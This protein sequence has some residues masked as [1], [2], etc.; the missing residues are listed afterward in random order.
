MIPMAPPMDFWGERPLDS[1]AIEVFPGNRKEPFT[2]Y[3]DDGL[4]EAYRRGAAATTEF[5]QSLD[6][7][8]LTL[9]VA[10]RKGRYAGM[11]ARRHYAFE[12]H[13]PKPAAVRVNGKPTNDWHYDEEAGLLA[14]APLPA[15]TRRPLEIQAR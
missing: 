6:G 12:I 4:T 1:L 11:P 13:R 3:E 5:N 7:G 14:L 10:P 8:L 2:L 15:P 9:T